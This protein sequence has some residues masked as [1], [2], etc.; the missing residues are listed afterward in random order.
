MNTYRIFIFMF[1]CD[2][3]R[4]WAL[5]GIQKAIWIPAFAGMMP[6]IRT[7]ICVEWY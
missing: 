1:C 5:A 3:S 6:G 2:R 7:L 4:S